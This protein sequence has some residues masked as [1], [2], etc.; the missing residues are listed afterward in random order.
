MTIEVIFSSILLVTFAA[1]VLRRLRVYLHV[2]QQEEYDGN[3]FLPWVVRTISFDKKVSV[4]LFLL[5][6][7]T[8]AF[9]AFIWFGGAALIFAIATFFERNPKKEG[10]KPLVM[11]QRAKRIYILAVILLLAASLCAV[12]LQWWAWIVL[13]QAIPVWLVIANILLKPVET[14]I[15]NSFLK[16]AKQKLVKLNPHTIGVTGSF[17]KTSVKH[18]LGHVLSMQAP[19]LITPGS[20]N[21][22]M[23]VTRIIREQLRDDHKYFIAEMGAYGPGSIKKL[24]DLV[25]PK[26]GIITAIGHAHYERFKTLE[27]V[28]R[29][30]FELAQAVIE[31]DG[32]II[33][34][35]SATI[36]PYPAQ[37]ISQHEGSFIISGDEKVNELFL[38]KVKQTT[39]GLD[40]KL[41][42]QGKSYKV[43]APLFG[44]HHAENIALVFA[45]ACTLGMEADIVITALKTAP[46]I[47][48][49]LEVTKQP[50]ETILVDDAYNS[51]PKGFAAALDILGMLKK[52]HK[53]RSILI[54]PGMVELG[55]S[56]DEEHR[57]I[58]EAAAG[59]VD[60]LLAV[61][62]E[63]IE[64][65]VD[66]FKK[67]KSAEQIVV[68]CDSFAAARQWLLENKKA[69]DIVLLE[70]DLPDLYE[71]KLNL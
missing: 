67:H 58:G 33:I 57:K 66:T 40:I 26:T 16:E 9:Y 6:F 38:E 42:W 31:N 35:H 61:T 4:S 51:N 65:F 8:E 60:V 10:K 55:T 11:T 29:A 30:K 43:F 1:F 64:S 21:T 20:V 45:T 22:P 50:D 18:L 36:A 32:K 41:N 3:R 37:F 23:G 28:A 15:Q 70:N 17:G 14:Y 59:N 39:K 63:R 44:A 7:A 69:N 25:P 2:F 54:T 27:T 71:V 49:R 46:Q 13:V 52:E 12:T 24:C 19:T 56:H 68:S 47:K 62:P 53:G 5:Y 34:S 48:H